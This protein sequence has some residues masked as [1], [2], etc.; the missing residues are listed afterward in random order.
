M[1]VYLKV[2]NLA[3]VEKV[4]LHFGPGFNVLTGETGAGK[5]ILIDALSLLL[6]KR[7][8]RDGQRDDNL[9]IV[10][11]ALFADGDE[12]TVLRREVSA[13]RSLCFI[14]EEAVPFARLM[15]EASSWLNIYGQ[16]DH[17]Y[18]LEQS[19]HLSYLDQYCGDSLLFDELK[20]AYGKVKTA[21]TELDRVKSEF[22]SAESRR[23]LLDFQVRELAQIDLKRGEEDE[24]EAKVKIMASAEEISQKT[25]SMLTDFYDGERSVYTLLARHAGQWASLRALFPQEEA[26]FEDLDRFYQTLPDLVMFLRRLGDTVE[27]DE[28]ELNIMQERLARISSLKKKHAT[29]FDGLLDR[30]ESLQLEAE[31]LNNLDFSIHE[32]EKAL[33]KELDAYVSV[34]ERCRALRQS[35]ADRLSSAVM[36]ELKELAM[37]KGEFRVQFDIR[38]P[39]LSNIS[40]SGCDHIE[41]YFS[42]NPG[43]PAGPI[44]EIASGGELSR[45]MLILKALAPSE[46]KAT[47]IF[48]EIDTGVGGKTA[49]FVGAR[50]KKIARQHQVLCISHLPQI[51]A[52]AAHHFLVEKRFEQDQTFSSVRRLSEMERIEEMARLMAGS[53][54]SESVRQAARDLLHAHQA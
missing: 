51:T 25:A 50:L 32:A 8:P 21:Q 29:T 9:A 45:L 20:T 13:G 48:D 54:G 37:P 34:H 22:Q 7:L 5:S 23:E 10:V 33:Q 24:L 43:Q 4:V 42:S 46:G 27:F 18:L 30:L 36:A 19:N 38:Q 41:F 26:L 49:E 40:P 31:R 1:L 16:R 44:R 52:C 6:S 35:G 3:V 12:E 28:Q 2:Q 47:Y 14:N 15:T 39:S 11:E 53:S 17:L